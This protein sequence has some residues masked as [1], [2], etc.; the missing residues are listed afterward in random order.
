MRF[1]GATNVATDF[2]VQGVVRRGSQATVTVL[3]TD[4]IAGRAEP[5]PPVAETLL[6]KREGGAW[7]LRPAR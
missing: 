7:V 2:R 3:R 5:T 4:V 1:E 6:F